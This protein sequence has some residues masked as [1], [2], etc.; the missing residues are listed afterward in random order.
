MTAS[1]NATP[2]PVIDATPA[3]S[4]EATSTEPTQSETPDVSASPVTHEQL[5]TALTKFVEGRDQ[6]GHAFAFPKGRFSEYLNS[7]VSLPENIINTENT[8]IDLTAPAVS[9]NCQGVLLGE[10]EVLNSKTNTK[11]LVAYVGFESMSADPRTKNF[12]VPVNLGR[13]GIDSDELDLTSGVIWNSPVRQSKMLP[14]I[15]MEQE[16]HQL[17]GQNIL[18]GFAI[19]NGDGLD[20]LRQPSDYRSGTE[21]LAQIDISKALVVWMEKTVDAPY[22]TLPMDP[23]IR[24]VVN[25]PVAD[26]V[27]LIPSTGN[28]SPYPYKLS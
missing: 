16:L 6:D 23:L 5:M 12:Y 11:S 26:L 13:V 3:R 1:L 22:Q 28:I 2:T 17:N 10:E 7:P 9:A 4:A 15:Q 27:N 14:V 24:S 8:K 25:H 21:Y 20:L 19:Y 18:T